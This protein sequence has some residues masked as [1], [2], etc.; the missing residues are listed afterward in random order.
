MRQNFHSKIIGVFFGSAFIFSGCGTNRE[1]VFPEKTSLTESV[2]SSV[3]VQPDSMYQAYAT[4]A[5]IIDKNLVVEGDTVSRGAPLVQ[6]VNTTPKLDTQNAGLALQLAQEKYDGTSA[7]LKG[8]KDEIAAAE[9]KFQ[10]DSISYF[11]QQRL[12]SQGIG[13]KAEYDNLKLAYELSS[14]DL[15]LLE[16]RYE[17]TKNELE[18]YVKQARNKYKAAQVTTGD[19]TVTS[20]IRGKVY[21][22]LKNQGEIVTTMEPLAIIG[23][24]ND[25]VI[26]MLVDEVDIV[27]I[28]IGQKTLITLDAYKNEVFNAKVSKIYP[29]KDERLQTFK[30]EALFDNPPNTLYPGLAGEGNII[31]DMREDVLT[32]PKAFLVNGNEVE[33]AQGRIQLQLG[34]ENLERVEVIDGID[35][36]TE[37]LMPEK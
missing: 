32:I 5:G 8:I 20:K 10:N 33:T 15:S 19:F 3:T 18:S 25:F 1:R 30:V 24:S 22:V 16:Q 23:S 35:S 4:V 29:R 37:I 21:A 31:I 12:W 17:S 9:L 6:L 2:Y 11:R 28:A 7:I 26:E 14:N 13:S 34:L 27:K 36:N